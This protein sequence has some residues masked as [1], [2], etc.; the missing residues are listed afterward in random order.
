MSGRLELEREAP[1]RH[2]GA[3]VVPHS[4]DDSAWGTLQI[5]VVAVVGRPGPTVLLTGGSHGDELEGPIVLGELS[6]T[7][8]P[9]ALTGRVLIV[10]AM[11]LPALEAGRRLS[12]I[13]GKNMNRVFPGDAAGSITE[14]IAEV[15]MRELVEPASVVVDLHAGG[16]SLEFVP[17]S[18]GHALPDAEPMR[19]T[20]DALRAFGAP[21]A[22]VL[23]ELDDAGLLDTE[24]ERRGKTFVS[25][26][27]G[28]GARVSA[29][30]LA[31]GRRGVRNLL[32]HAGVLD[33][34]PDVPEPSRLMTVPPDGYVLAQAEGLFEPLVELGESVDAGQA[35]ARVHATA[36]FEGEP[37]T[38]VAPRSGMLVGSR[39]R[40]A[41]TR[42]D[43]LA[44]LAEDYDG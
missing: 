9:A 7:L 24:V 21:I 28:G 18:I 23:H 43:C 38:H 11:N 31:I 16:Q 29:R 44:V 5:P 25:T 37:R 1:G 33:A 27:L 14:K 34:A 10:P 26:E 17:T 15:V 13:D 22:L 35:V 4:R 6:R 30:S 3:V 19:R 32:A 12:P 41:T 8:D 42:G 40:A 36:D 2:V 39:A 20:V